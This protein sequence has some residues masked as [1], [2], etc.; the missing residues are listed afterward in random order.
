MLHTKRNYSLPRAGCPENVGLDSQ[1]IIDLIN[2]LL[3]ADYELHSMMI[4]RNGLVAAECYR[5]P[6]N[7]HTTHCLYSVSK[8]VTATALGFAISEGKVS[9]DTKV[10]DIFPDKYPNKKDDDFEKLTLRHLVTM[11]SGKSPSPLLNKSKGDWYR[12]LSEAKRIAAPGKRFQYVNECTYV[13]SACLKRVLGKGINDYLEPRLWNPLGIDKPFWETDSNGIEAGGWGLQM[14]TEDIAKL[15][16]CYHNDGVFNGEQVIP[17][18]WATQ[19]KINQTTEVDYAETEPNR[20][21]YSVWIEGDNCWRFDGMYGQTAQVFKKEDIIIVING[22]D[23]NHNRAIPFYYRFVESAIIEPDENATASKE[24]TEFMTSQAIDEFKASEI[25]SPIEQKLEGRIIKFRHHTILNTIGFSMGIL[26]PP[27]VYMSKNRAG[28]VGYAAF[29]FTDD[30]CYFTWNEGEEENTVFCAM[31]GG[32]AESKITLGEIPFTAFSAARWI[33]KKT[34]EIKIRPMQS[35]AIRVLT[36]TFDGN[37]VSVESESSP[38][39]AEII[40]S[41]SGT[42]STVVKNEKL[43]K[44]IKEKM[45]LLKKFMEPTTVGRFRK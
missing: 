29:N 34:L 33:D 3:A 12:H 2:E 17:Q 45:Y 38:G 4:I 10:S 35:I 6:F 23:M 15:A 26:P 5:Y 27:A 44:T 32:Y 37:K 7:P 22:G 40:N 21:G 36:F 9:L 16:L 18:E 8:N 11:T 28:N 14:H 25:R 19:A 43:Q 41:I 31:N 1:K 42:V 20:Y 24:F 30:G 39:T 13:L